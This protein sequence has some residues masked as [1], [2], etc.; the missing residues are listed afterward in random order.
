MTAEGLLEAAGWYPGRD[1]GRL[2]AGI[3]ELVE[4]GFPVDESVERL[5]REYSGLAIGDEA[6][7]RYLWV[8]GSRAAIEADPDWVAAYSKDLHLRLAPI[9]GYSHMLVMA[10]S[11]GRCWGGFDYEYGLLGESLLSTIDAL[12]AAGP[13]PRLDRRLPDG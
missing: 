1:V 8:D 6:E 10:D 2:G 4:A 13:V 5:L 9:G 12:L 3:A 11:A 7:A